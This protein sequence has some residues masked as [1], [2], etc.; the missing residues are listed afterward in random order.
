MGK[1]LEETKIFKSLSK[2]ELDFIYSFGHAL[3]QAYPQT[4]RFENFDYYIGIKVKGFSGSPILFKK[5]KDILIFH[6]HDKG[7]K[8]KLDIEV[9]SLDE[10]YLQILMSIVK[11][12]YFGNGYTPSAPKEP[13]KKSNSRRVENKFVDGL[14]EDQRSLVIKYRKTIVLM[15][16]KTFRFRDRGNYFEIRVGGERDYFFCFRMKDNVFVFENKK[17]YPPSNIIEIKDSSEAT[18]DSILKVTID[19]VQR[20]RRKKL[21]ISYEEKKENVESFPET[22]SDNFR[23]FVM[24]FSKIIEEHYKARFYVFIGEKYISFKEIKTEVAFFWFMKK[25]GTLYFNYHPKND[26]QKQEAVINPNKETLLALLRLAKNTCDSYGVLSSYDKPKKPIIVEQKPQKQVQ[27][28]RAVSNNTTPSVLNI[29][30]YIRSEIRGLNYNAL[31]SVKALC[32]NIKT[33]LLDVLNRNRKI[34][35]VNIIE[36]CQQVLFY[37]N[38]LEWSEK[39]WLKSAKIVYRYFKA[40]TLVEKVQYYEDVRQKV[41]CTDY[42]A[43]LNYLYVQIASFNEID[44]S[45][46]PGITEDFSL[47]PISALNDVLDNFKGYE[48]N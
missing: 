28:K 33:Y 23:S 15:F 37:G 12:K 43:L 10:K 35:I 32:R 48:I 4:F 47:I 34:K 31:P 19:E 26:D 8:N 46:A 11:D 20:Y 41:M 5:P 14:N 13:K 2:D 40:N 21:T 24:S 25:N 3:K 18:L 29:Y 39:N 30:S 22:L 6:W 45:K 38:S 17:G 36:A 1:K 7:R 42:P 16:S 27:E 44:Y 9:R